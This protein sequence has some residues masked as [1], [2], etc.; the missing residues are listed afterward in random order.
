M[1]T[2]QVALLAA[3]LML[4]AVGVVLSTAQVPQ[5]TSKYVDGSLSLDPSSS[6]WAN[7]KK[8]EV[9]L[10]AQRIVYPLSEA[11]QRRLLRVASAYNGTHLAI[12]I[13]WED[14]SPD[15]P[16]PG[17]LNNFSDMVAVQFPLREGE[18][19]YVCMGSV[20]NPVVIALWRAPNSTETL[21]AGSGYGRDVKGREALELLKTPSSPIE[22]LPEEAQV[23]SSAATY[24]DGKWKVVL[25]RPLGGAGGLSSIRPGGSTSVAFARWEGSLAE[26][27]GMKSTSSWYTLVLQ[28]PAPLTTTAPAPAPAAPTP[29]PSPLSVAVGVAA[30]AV[31]G[32]LAFAA[33]LHLLRRK[34]AA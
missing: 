1:V 13:E 21:I 26:R 34:G 9:P 31:A 7:A 11:A 18:L 4:A 5:I 33:A 14:S 29:T 17:G 28:A 30:A 27:G 19:P 20:D 2:L 3:A 15:T 25:Y 8:A 12:Y 6:F 10:A 16:S 24:S 23:W 32:V 22:R